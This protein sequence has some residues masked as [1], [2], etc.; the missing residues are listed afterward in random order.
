MV[1]QTRDIGPLDIRVPS[2]QG[3]RS[4]ILEYRGEVPFGPPFFLLWIQVDNAY[5]GPG[6]AEIYGDKAFWSADGR[7]L[8]LERWYSFETPDNGLVIID[9]KTEQTSLVSRL[10]PR[11]LYDVT[12]RLDTSENQHT[13]THRT[14][15]YLQSEG[16]VRNIAQVNVDETLAWTS[17]HWLNVT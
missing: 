5:V 2:P 10:G 9:L 4:I 3:D 17:V 6:D 1:R 8:A 15:H 7:Y 14:E 13:I 12:W 11:F 16:S